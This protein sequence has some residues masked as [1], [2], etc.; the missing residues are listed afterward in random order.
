MPASTLEQVSVFVA[1]LIM[2]TGS[3]VTIK[4]IYDTKSTD[5][6]GRYRTFEK[7][8]TTT[9]TMFIAMTLALPF[10]FVM[11]A[12]QKH[13]RSREEK[14]GDDSYRLLSDGSN[15][16][17]GADSQGLVDEYV[18]NEDELEEEEEEEV[19]GFSRR[20]FWLL[21]IP[22]IFDLVG[23]ALGKMGLMFVTVSLYQLVRC[24]VII[25]VALLKVF[26]LKHK[27]SSYMWAGVFIN[28][29]AMCVISSTS[30]FPST[31][32]GGANVT[33]PAGGEGGHGTENKDPR[34]GILFI[35][36]SCAVQGAQY[37][38]EEQV[39][40]AD[41]AHPLVVVGMEGFWGTILMFFFVFPWAY[42]LPGKDT[43]DC[44]ENLWDSWIMIQNSTAVQLILF[45]FFATVALY[46]IFA[47]MVTHVLDSVWHAILDNFRPISVWGTDL[48]IF[49]VIAAP[50]YGEPWTNLS[51]IQLVG[52]FVLFFGTAVYNGSLKLPCLSYEEP[53]PMEAAE[54]Y[55]AELRAMSEE[56]PGS[57]GMRAHLNN[58][59][60]WRSPGGSRYEAPAFSS[61]ALG[62][63]SPSIVRSPLIAKASQA[64]LIKKEQRKLSQ[65]D[66][67]QNRHHEER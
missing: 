51:Y 19:P 61:T 48:F 3:T 58:I 2:G 7:P 62:L 45:G 63:A 6:L 30:F 26:V 60:S 66:L 27:L 8:L 59:R 11:R 14:K 5:S 23:T 20:L 56:E 16:R 12:V 55:D 67:T 21:I 40:E 4:V 54:A 39:M 49:Y 46:N 24:S 1:G 41:G 25:I 17:R 35:L 9:W 29:A 38:F 31:P 37:V 15:G 64:L 65:Y 52:M 28:L 34:I 22:A 33:A 32:V 53:T 10:Y 44:F 42:I 47:I 43:G 50:G 36:A 57:P 18:V 13:L